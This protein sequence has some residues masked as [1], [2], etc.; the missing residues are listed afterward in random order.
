MSDRTGKKTG[1]G[2]GTE[3]GPLPTNITLYTNISTT[4]PSETTQSRPHYA[5]ASENMT[6]FGPVNG[7]EDSQAEAKPHRYHVL[8][9]STPVS[10]DIPVSK[11]V[12]AK[13]YS[14]LKREEPTSNVDAE[15]EYAIAAL[16]KV[17]LVPASSLKTEGEYSEPQDQLYPPDAQLALLNT[18]SPH[19][20]GDDS[21]Y[22]EP[23]NTK[24]RR[25]KKRPTPKP[26]PDAKPDQEYAYACPPDALRLPSVEPDHIT[27]GDSG[28]E[29][30]IS[31]KNTLKPSAKASSQDTPEEEL[32]AVI[33]D[34]QAATRVPVY[35]SD[36]VQKS[37]DQVIVGEDLYAA[38]AVKQPGKTGSPMDE[39]SDNEQSNMTPEHY[40]SGDDWYAVSAKPSAKQMIDQTGRKSP[41]TEYRNHRPVS[42]QID[43]LVCLLDCCIWLA[44]L[45]VEGCTIS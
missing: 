18:D 45:C 29:Y 1:N 14:V 2:T 22:T 10:D 9:R 42:R 34:D 36:A 7:N 30:A 25:L 40:E 16:H 11:G 32:Y 19:N 43:L 3:H 37:R 27:V 12:A 24:P 21:L 39:N 4:K 33:A 26:R 17:H 8:D 13:G 38:V 44:I 6:S 20:I 31:L 35:G 41:S 5:N 15:N 23:T 28:D